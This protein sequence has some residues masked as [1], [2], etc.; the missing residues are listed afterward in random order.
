[1]SSAAAQ[2]RRRIM[3]GCAGWS[4]DRRHSGL[5]GEGDSQL[6]RYATVFDAVEINSSFYR[7][8][9][10]KTYL[11]WAQSVPAHFR[12]SVKLPRAISH[13]A[14]LRKT[15]P[16]LDRFLDE[17]AGLGDKLGVL[18]LQLPPSLAFEAR[19]VAAFMRVLRARW[20]GEVVCEPRHPSWF[21]PA[22]SALIQRYR[23]GRVGAD[24]ALSDAARS[25]MGALL[26][27]RWH[28]SPRMYHSAY[29]SSAL[30][31]LAQDL[32]DQPSATQSWAIFDNTASGHALT[33]ALALRELCKR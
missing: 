25:P 15:G 23:V 31:G 13:D 11:R 3:I 7:P 28:G 10:R 19:T 30:V 4:I 1:M 22:A 9:Q 14:R 27:W 32:R 26:Y 16:L 12:Y 18:L 2:A 33:D 6:A 17:V 29:T 20:N 24:P 21:R 5:F 8:H